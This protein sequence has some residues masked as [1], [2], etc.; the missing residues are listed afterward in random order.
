[1]TTN[2]THD[3]AEIRD[4]IDVAATAMRGRDADAMVARYTDD[5]V[6]YS[7]AP[8][9]RQ[10]TSTSVDPGTVRAWF[11]GFDGPID[12]AVRDLEISVGGDVAYCHGLNR[13]TATPA[14]APE[15]FTLWFRFTA[16]LRKVGGGWRIAHLHEST[17]FYMDM[18]P[19]GTFRAAVDLTP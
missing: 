13:L 2:T 18:S 14:G 11:A 9:L 16:G 6:E 3:E 17:P 10:E 15:S 7:L 4:L 19:D 5:V 1:M 8:P 12:H